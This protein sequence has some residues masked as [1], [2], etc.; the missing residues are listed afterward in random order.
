MP[1]STETCDRSE[2]C[3]IE[4]TPGMIEA[5]MGELYAFNPERSGYTAEEAVA[6]IYR[7]MERARLRD[8]G[9]RPNKSVQPKRKKPKRK[10]PDK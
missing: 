4:I 7:L 8:L 10:T 9:D 1:L 2:A 6:E 5:G 3:E